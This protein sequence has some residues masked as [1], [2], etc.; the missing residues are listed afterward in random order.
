MWH[1]SD[2][3]LFESYAESLNFI[4]EIYE[5][6]PSHLDEVT[7]INQ[8]FENFATY[9][10]ESNIFLQEFNMAHNKILMPSIK[11]MQLLQNIYNSLPQDYFVAINNMSSIVESLNSFLRSMDFTSYAA[12]LPIKDTSPDDYIT[13]DSSVIK[14]L[15]ISDNFSITIGSNLIRI[16]TSDFIALIALIFSIFAY[17]FPRIEKDTSS[18]VPPSNEKVFLETQNQS[19]EDIISVSQEQNQLLQDENQL[20]QEKNQ[21]IQEKNQL[22]REENQLIQ[23]KNQLLQ[24]ENQLIQ[25]KN[26]FLQEENQ[27]TQGEKQFL[28]DILESVNTSM[29]SQADFFEE[30][31]TFLSEQTPTAQESIEPTKILP[32]SNESLPDNAPKSA[33]LSFSFR[34]Q[35]Q[36][37]DDSTQQKIDSSPKSLNT[38]SESE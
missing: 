24:E 1:H 11:Q 10:T 37:F 33:E 27:L 17:L 23:E 22:L 2:K 28:L 29:S 8:Q 30:M 3:H 4:N 6:I 31:K 34:E 26:Q 9:L 13:T 32:D 20:I 5:R 18:E 35:H 12:S 16:K 25:E 21:L 15:D 38:Y 36:E 19:E 7:Y 14:T